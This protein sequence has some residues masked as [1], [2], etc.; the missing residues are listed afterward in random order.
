MRYCWQ[1]RE[2]GEMALEM[3]G[4][5]QFVAGFCYSATAE[6]HDKLKFAGHF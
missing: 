4:K 6:S 3:S 1:T 2:H 5:L